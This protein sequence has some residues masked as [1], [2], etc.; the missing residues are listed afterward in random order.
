MRQRT[1]T[2]L[3]SALQVRV[4]VRVRCGRNAPGCVAGAAALWPNAPHRTSTCTCTTHLHC[5]GGIGA[6][7][8]APRP[9][10]VARLGVQPLPQPLAAMG[11]PIPARCPFRAGTKLA[12]IDAFLRANPLHWEIGPTHI[13]IILM[14]TFADGT[15]VHKQEVWTVLTAWGHTRKKIAKV[16]AKSRPHERTA[17]LQVM[18]SLWVPNRED[19]VRLAGSMVGSLISSMAHSGSSS[20]RRPSRGSR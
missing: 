2:H 16:P 20:M 4:Q 8:A 6:M 9:L 7:A 11:G 15:E 12:R 1:A 3:Q 14:M 19:M 5:T 10:Q 13:A 17:H 18:R